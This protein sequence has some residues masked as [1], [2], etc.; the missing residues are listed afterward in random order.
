MKGHVLIAQLLK[1]S[2]LQKYKKGKGD[3]FYPFLSP[4]FQI[5]ISLSF[6]Y[7]KNKGRRIE[8]EEE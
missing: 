7:M 8:T 3:I 5:R 6:Q 4:Q 2:Y 1:Y